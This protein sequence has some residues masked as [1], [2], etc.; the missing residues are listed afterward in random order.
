VQRPQIGYAQDNYGR[1]VFGGTAIVF[2][3]LLGNRQLVTAAAINGRV[4]EA[5][6]F[7]DYTSLSRRLSWSAGIQQQPYFFLANANQNDLGSGQ[8]QV[9]EELD[10]YII[11]SAFFQSIYPRNRFQRFEIGASFTNIDKSAEFVSQ[12]AD[13]NTGY[14]TGYYVDSIKGTGSFNFASPYV[15]YVSDNALFGSTGPIYGHRYRYEVGSNFGT[16]S[17]MSYIADIRRYDALIFSYLT[18]ATRLYADVNVGGGE[19]LF[20][21]YL[22]NPN[23]LSYVR[24]YDRDSYISGTCGV[25]TTTNSACSSTELLGSRIAL[26]SVEL[27]F[28]LIRRFDLGFLPITMPPVDGLFFYDAGMAWT[29]GQNVTLTQPANYD[30][31]TMRYPLRSFGYGVR[32]N[33]FNIAILKFDYA[34]PRDS[35]NRTGYWS[36]SIGQSF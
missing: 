18:L 17:W 22:G 23:G 27:R 8:L 30:P 2:G 25:A 12:I 4:E 5:Q 19:T 24:G 21:Q 10:R 15:A 20:P 11:R 34:I 9:S 32:V 7:I 16:Q 1:G 36:W 13:L 35:S 6:I 14:S 31:N 28:P 26:G 3:D 29:A 33:V